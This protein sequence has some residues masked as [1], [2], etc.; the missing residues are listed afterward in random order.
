MVAVQCSGCAP[1]VKAF[2]SGG[3]TSEFWRDPHTI[4]SGLRVPKA[5]ADE[6]ILSALY[7]S[8]GMAVAVEDSELLEDL[9][10]V[11]RLEGMLM[12]PEGAAAITAVRHLVAENKLGGSEKVLVYNTG[13]GYKYVEALRAAL[14]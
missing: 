13:S 3:R 4:A 2:A 1:I 12:C 8:K 14:G 11:A 10:L 6:L 5:F 9:K 7:E